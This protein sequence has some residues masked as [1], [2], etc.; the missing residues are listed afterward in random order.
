MLSYMYKRKIL[1][2][3]ILQ[4]IGWILILVLTHQLLQQIIQHLTEAGH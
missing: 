1:L 3:Y 2:Q 4:S